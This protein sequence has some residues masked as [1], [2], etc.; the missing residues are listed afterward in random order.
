ISYIL[1][2][3]IPHVKVQGI[4]THVRGEID[5]VQSI[6]VNVANRH[7]ATVIEIFVGEHVCR[8]RFVQNIF[9]G[10]ARF[11]RRKLEKE[12]TVLAEKLAGDND[13]QELENPWFSHHR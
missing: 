3:E 2:F 10:N 12:G 5:I 13:Q 9:E 6:A 4:G 8:G 1:E 7:T 11:R